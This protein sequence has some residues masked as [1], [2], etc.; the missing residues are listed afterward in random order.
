MA[1]SLPTGLVSSK[2][3][4][5]GPTLGPTLGQSGLWVALPPT[6]Q[7]PGPDTWNLCPPT[8]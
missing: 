7:Q 4:M 1:D 8:R 5:L 6:P 2:L 3:P